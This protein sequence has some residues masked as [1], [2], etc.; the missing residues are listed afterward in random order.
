MSRSLPTP[1][2]AAAG[3]WEGAASSL[4]VSHG[5]GLPTIGLI[6]GTGYISDGPLTGLTD[7]SDIERGIFQVEPGQIR[8]HCLTAGKAL[9]WGSLVGEEVDRSAP[10]PGGWGG[11][12]GSRTEAANRS[13]MLL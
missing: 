2:G 12:S 13:T 5:I 9:P 11:C 7:T 3:A 4:A 6:G 10:D 1:C 8:T